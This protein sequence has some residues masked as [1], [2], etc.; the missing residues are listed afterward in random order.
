M[1]PGRLAG[2]TAAKSQRRSSLPFQ[3]F[4]SRLIASASEC[5]HLPL[6]H[7]EARVPLAPRA[8]AAERSSGSLAG[9]AAK[10]QRRSSLPFQLFD[11]RLFAS[12][13][14]GSHL[15]LTHKEEPVP[16]APRAPAAERSS[17]GSAGRAWGGRGRRSSLPVLGVSVEGSPWKA[18]DAWRPD[19]SHRLPD[20]P[21][22]S[23]MRSP[24]SPQPS[25][26]LSPPISEG[27]ELV[28]G[29]CSS[30]HASATHHSRLDQESCL[31][32]TGQVSALT[33]PTRQSPFDGSAAQRHD[34][35][36]ESPSSGLASEVTLGITT[37]DSRLYQ[38]SCLNSTG[39]VSAFTSPSRQSPFDGSAAERHDPRSESPSSGLFSEVTFGLTTGASPLSQVSCGLSTLQIAD[40]LSLGPSEIPHSQR[41]RSDGSLSP[42]KAFFSGG[43]SSGARASGHRSKLGLSRDYAVEGLEQVSLAGGLPRSCGGGG[44]GGHGDAM[45]GD[46]TSEDKRR[47]LPAAM[48]MLGN[49][50]MPI[51]R[52]STSHFSTPRSPDIGDLSGMER[53]PSEGPGLVRAQRVDRRVSISSRRAAS[54]MNNFSSFTH[55]TT[56]DYST[57]GQLSEGP[58][59]ES[60]GSTRALTQ[61]LEKL[62]KLLPGKKAAQLAPEFS[63]LSITHSGT[64]EHNTQWH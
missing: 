19:P 52:F 23:S 57:E 35:R 7:E 31:N 47:S 22:G 34:P 55:A 8:P 44:G 32:S 39:Q 40:L 53:A 43:H 18:S 16:L 5:S 37:H 11:S 4:D 6:T 27:E 51:R 50:K 49:M 64:D 25:R 59:K 20:R 45:R 17:G 9:I 1:A 46:G 30:R 12:S 21:L 56:S 33:S 60:K 54:D 38:E 13:W 62:R 15:P 24:T 14:G 10:S 42:M 58:D 63:P 41:K 3:L 29:P 28:A 36:S 48:G 2:S 26:P 61:G